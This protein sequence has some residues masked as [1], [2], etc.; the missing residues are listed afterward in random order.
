[1]SEID[2]RYTPLPLRMSR[3][4]KPWW[5]RLWQW[6]LYG[7]PNVDLEPRPEWYTDR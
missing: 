4:R 7:R 2:L 1:M 5:A 3:K 6:L